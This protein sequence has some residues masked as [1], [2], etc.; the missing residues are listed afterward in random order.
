[1]TYNLGGGERMLADVS[2]AAFHDLR[3]IYWNGGI[4]FWA[5]GPAPPGTPMGMSCLN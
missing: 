5:P 1:M 4:S 3:I 2:E